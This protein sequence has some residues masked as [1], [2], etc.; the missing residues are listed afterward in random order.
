M[1]VKHLRATVI[2]VAGGKGVRMGVPLPKQYISL[3]GRPVLW[4]TLQ[5]FEEAECISSIVLV[6]SADDMAYCQQVVLGILLGARPRSAPR[7]GRAEA[8]GS[9]AAERA[10]GARQEKSAS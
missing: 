6:V 7:S 4:H 9:A 8:P 5:S 2:I 1:S 3:H 10:G